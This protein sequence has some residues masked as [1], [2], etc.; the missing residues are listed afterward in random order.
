MSERISMVLFVG[1]IVGLF[2]V[3]VYSIK[4]GKGCNVTV[5]LT[6]GTVLKVS[7]TISWRNGM[8]DIISCKGE[9]IQVP[10]ARI[11]VIK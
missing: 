9:K 5:V 4:R 3:G 6:D 10:T 7:E 1:L 2:T 11:K 8:T